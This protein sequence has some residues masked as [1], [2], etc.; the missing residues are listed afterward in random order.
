M[1]GR[2][3]FV[4]WSGG[5]DSTYLI[6]HLCDDPTVYE[7]LAGY[8]HVENSA[9]KSESERA[10]IERMVPLLRARS[11]KF[12]WLGVLM[13]IEFTKTNPNL[14]FKQVPVWMLAALEAIHPP[15]D[16]IAIGYHPG[17]DAAGR[18]E[19]L[20][21]IYAAYRPL[22]HR[23]PPRL[24]FPLRGMGKAEIAERI[25]PALRAATVWCEAPRVVPATE[26]ERGWRACGVC[27]TCKARAKA[28]L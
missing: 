21:R 5:L 23:D 1:S 7:V 26:G 24:V 12:V 19:D 20:E 28:G 15:V 4:L 3:V 2:V 9:V 11:D 25:D 17:D 14:A 27:G 22:M 10:A 6:Q 18:L 16:E 13:Q 8:V